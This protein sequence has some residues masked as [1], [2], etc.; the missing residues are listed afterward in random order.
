MA[1]YRTKRQKLE[2][3]AAQS[4]SPQ[5]A[6]VARRKLAELPENGLD[7]PVGRKTGPRARW[8]GISPLPAWWFTASNSSHT[9]DDDPPRGPADW[10]G[11]KFEEWWEQEKR[12]KP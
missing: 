1:D 2:A 8:M 12:R 5:E 7:Q 4:V 3:M 11:V 6:E 10:V 9:P